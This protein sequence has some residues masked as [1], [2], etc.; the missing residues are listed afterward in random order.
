MRIDG[1]RNLEPTAELSGS[2]SGS[3]LGKFTNKV[4]DASLSGSFSGS[5]LGIGTGSFSGS[6]SGD[7]SGLGNVFKKVVVA[8]DGIESILSAQNSGVMIFTSESGAGLRITHQQNQS[9]PE[10]VFDLIKLGVKI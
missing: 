10:I 2:F 9:T 3:F 5:F 1:P 7:G 6:F 4:A 8:P